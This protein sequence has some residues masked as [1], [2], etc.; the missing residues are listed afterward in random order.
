MKSIVLIT[1]FMMMSLLTVLFPSLA[2][3]V[4]LVMVFL[5]GIPHGALDLWILRKRFAISRFKTTGLFIAYLSLAI[6]VF[7]GFYWF[8]SFF[9]GFFLVYSAYHFGMDYY[10]SSFFQAKFYRYFLALVIGLSIIC[11]PALLHTQQI[12]VLFSY[13]IGSEH[14]VLYAHFLQSAACGL[15]PVTSLGLFTLK[16]DSAHEVIIV[17]VAALLVPPLAFLTVYFVGIHSCK[18]F[19][20]LYKNMGY[21]SYRAFVKDL[22]PMTLLTYIFSITAYAFLPSSLDWQG[23]GFFLTVYLLAA[24]TLPH[25]ILVEVFKKKGV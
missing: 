16:K 21:S 17:L 12:G 8:S 20:M 3:I 9:F 4:F 6:G 5:I 13:L 15:L 2:M 14:A 7:L 10:D 11:L 22:L 23:A 19:A 24:L 18:Y 1:H 25:M